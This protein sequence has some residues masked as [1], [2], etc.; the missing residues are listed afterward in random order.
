[1]KKKENHKI[2]EK[3]GDEEEKYVRIEE[4]EVEEERVPIG[5]SKKTS[6]IT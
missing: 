1:M 3:N 4:Y 5:T 2:S 6:K